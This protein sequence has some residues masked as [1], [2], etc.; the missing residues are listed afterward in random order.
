MSKKTYFITG[1]D[2]SAGKTVVTSALIRYWQK[3]GGRVAGLKPIASGFE[4]IDGEYKNED[5]E[6]IKAAN[7]VEL[8]DG[9]INRYAYRQ[10]VAPHI[11]AQQHKE[12]IEIDEIVNDAQQALKEVDTLIVEGVGGW[13]VPLN[14]YGQPYQDIQTL[15]QKLNSPVILVVSMRLGCI[16][17]ALLSAQSIMAS[18][19]PFHGWV[20]N[21]CDPL[22]ECVDENITMLD[23]QMPVPRLFDMPFV[24]S[25]SNF[26]EIKPV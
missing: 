24:E 14:G 6:S 19:V 22:L 8:K 12:R 16:N 18:G 25:L 13:L 15:A 23:S 4:L 20:A 9:L 7:N 2:T 26:K 10:A 1:T 17:H 21:F 5:I 3:D 11:V